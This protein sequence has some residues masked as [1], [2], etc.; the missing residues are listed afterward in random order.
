MRY[1][2]LLLVIVSVLFCY[3][4]LHSQSYVPLPYQVKCDPT[5]VVHENPDGTSTVK[6][7]FYLLKGGVPSNELTAGDFL[8]YDDGVVVPAIITEPQAGVNKKADIVFCLDI[9]GSMGD[10]INAVK[11]NITDF[12]NALKSG[13]FDVRLGLITFGQASQPRLRLRNNGQFYS[14]LQDFINEVSSLIASGGIEE[15]YDAIALASQYPFREGASRIIIL[16]TDEPGDGT[17]NYPNVDKAIEVVKKNSAKVY[18]I[19]YSGLQTVVKAV[20]ETGGKLYN[21]TDPFSDI[22]NDIANDIKN[23]YT[24]S[25]VTSDSPGDHAVTVEVVQNGSNCTAQFKIGANPTIKLTQ[26]TQ[27]AVNNGVPVGTGSFDIEAEIKDPDGSISEADIMINN[28]SYQMSSL[29]ADI[30]SY[31]VTNLNSPGDCVEFSIKAV[32]NEGRAVTKGPWKICVANSA[33]VIGSISPTSYDYGKDVNVSVDVTD[34]DG[35]PVTVILYYREKGQLSWS[36]TPMSESGGLFTATIPASVAGF[37]GIEVKVEASDPSG[38][39][40]TKTQTL[41]VNTIPVTIVS[42][43]RLTDTLDTGPYTIYAVV[44]GVDTTKGDTV[45]LD[46]SI[47]GQSGAIPMTLAVTGTSAPLQANSNIYVAEIPSVSPGDKVCYYVV[48]SNPT[49][50]ESSQE[51]C[52]KVLQP[53]EPLAITPASVRMCMGDDP[54]EFVATGGYGTY[55]WSTLSGDLST[56]LGD[57]TTYT[58][59]LTGFDKVVVKDIKGFTATAVVEVLP[60]LDISPDVNGK[61]FSPSSTVVLTASGCE[62]PYSWEVDGAKS[63]QVSGDDNETVTIELGAEPATITVTLKDSKGREKTVQFTNNGVLKINPSGEVTVPLG[64]EQKFTASGGVEPYTWS[65]VGGDLDTYTGKEVTYKAP[66]VAGVYHITVTD[67]NGD[68]ASATIKVGEPLRVTPRYARV[69]RGESV[70][71]QVVS[72]VPPYKWEAEYGELSSTTGDRVT[73][74][75]ESYLGL[76]R[77]NVYDSAGSVLTVTVQVIEGLVVTPSSAIVE[78]G[79]TKEFIVTGGSGNYI[80][81][82]KRGTVTPTTGNNVTYKAPDVLGDGKDEITVRDDAGNEAKVEI[83]LVV[84]AE[85][86]NELTITPKEVT[87]TPGGTQTFVVHNAKDPSLV[88]WSA[89]GGNIDSNGVYTAPDKVGVYIVTVIDLANGRQASATVKVVGELVITPTSAT[90]NTNESK[91]FTVSGGAEP[92]TWKVIG[93]GDLSS[94]TGSTVTFTASSKAGPVKLVVMDSQG[95]TAQAE[96]TVVGAMKISPESVT[97]A[98]GMTQKFTVYGGTG[99]IH[100]S[101]EKGD[102]DDTGL[103]TA[104]PDIGTYIITA[105]DDAGNVATATVTVGNVPVVTP[106]KAWL[107]LGESTTFEVVGGT[108]PYTWTASAGDVS[109]KTGSTVTYTAPDVAQEVKVTVTDSL[110]QKSEAIVYVDLP[111]KPSK[112]EIYIE[113]GATTEVSVYGGVPP[114]EWSV[115]RG[116]L[117]NVTTEEYGINTYTADKVQGEATIT[118]RDRRGS[119]VT[120]AVHIIKKFL[121]SPSIRYMDRGETKTFTVTGGVPPYTA[122]VLEGD[123]DIEPTTCNEDPCVFSFTAGNVAD[124]DVVIQFSDSS[125]KEFKAHAY[126]ERKLRISFA[127]AKIPRGATVKFRVTGGYGGYWAEATSGEIDV[128]PETGR[129]TYKAP[130]TVGKVTITVVDAA[131]QEVTAV[132]EVVRSTPVISPS[133]VTMNPGDTKT[134]MVTMGTGP[135]EWSFEGGTYTCMDDECSVIQITAPEKEG[136]Y[137]LTVEDANGERPEEPAI[138]EVK[139]PLLLSPSSYVVYK[140]ESPRVRITALGGSP[141]YDFVVSGVEE[142]ARGDDYVVVAPRT[143][144]EE[145]T[146]YTVT[147]RDSTGETV[148]MKIVVSRL[149]GDI[150][151]DGKVDDSEMDLV[152]KSFTEGTPVGGVVVEDPSLV[153]KHIEVY[154]KTE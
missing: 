59:K 106:K 130:K 37:N 66:E 122:I 3:G 56:T 136:I 20:K 76:Y 40:S 82:A 152:I 98:P 14:S 67:A 107:G 100:W 142:I 49:D 22:L 65:V 19:S 18:G 42:V 58:P 48:A 87:L 105:M 27:D 84:S 2:K 6:L 25:F 28:S 7:N 120:I 153:Y 104:P 143:D 54:I 154:E 21:I 95:R 71:F 116:D 108:P 23:M 50:T 1:N 134:F 147:C 99:N 79:K 150:N 129:G 123:G 47:D 148:S 112:E 51:I 36:S 9:S 52:F 78:L 117:G 63:F 34:P 46:Y 10:E 61:R 57:K 113:P 133:K 111:M 140:G 75:P 94:T 38:A 115:T 74:T 132:V 138:I 53:V 26:A 149:P 102:I 101:A 137:Q 31:T 124:E 12:V 88:K 24:L 92:Y 126:V 121:V 55:Q 30:Y 135:Y 127:S 96:I 80:W 146:E 15:W 85:K 39:V 131:D 13:N 119:T 145:G 4:V 141:P 103:Y 97:L 144:V 81:S 90:L 68:Y 86:L 45:E 114:F 62:P 33:P 5:P 93:E 72:G 83:T 91:D 151:G 118:V 125:G 77:I 17:A 70:E 41:T 109:P 32:D 29:G 11:N 43:T 73:Y 110:G 64:G 60:A 44:A 8:V 128:D 69:L 35:D 16:I 139:L 89:T